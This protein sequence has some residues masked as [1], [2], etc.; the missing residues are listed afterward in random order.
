L[1]R[2]YLFAGFRAAGKKPKPESRA[3][4]AEQSTE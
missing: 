4:R 3:A 2:I 1:F